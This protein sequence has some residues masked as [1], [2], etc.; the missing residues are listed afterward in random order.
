MTEEDNGPTETG[1]KVAWKEKFVPAATLNGMAG[2]PLITKFGFPVN[3][4][5]VTWR[6]VLA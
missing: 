4:R 3:A 1:A 5:A 2:R 6:A